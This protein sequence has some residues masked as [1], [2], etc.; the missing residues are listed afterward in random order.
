[1]GL[2]NVFQNFIRIKNKKISKICD[3]DEE[4]NLLEE[5]FKYVTNKMMEEKRRYLSYSDFKQIITSIHSS[6]SFSRSLVNV[7]EKESI[8]TRTKVR[9]EL[10]IRFSYDRLTDFYIANYLINDSYKDYLLD[11]KY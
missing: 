1:M 3:I 4:D 11:E 6:V 2:L 8:I 10:K 9:N 7:L 5:V